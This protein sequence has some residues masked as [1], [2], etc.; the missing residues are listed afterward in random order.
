MD[1]EELFN[2]IPEKKAKEGPQQSKKKQ[3][4]KKPVE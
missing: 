3:A 2:K 4:A 1:I